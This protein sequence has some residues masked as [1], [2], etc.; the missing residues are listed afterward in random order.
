MENKRI[1]LLIL[2]IFFI[3]INSF[4]CSCVPSKLSIKQKQ[5][6]ENSECVFIG[7]VININSENNTYEIIVKESIDGNESIGEIFIGKNHK[8]CTPNITK[9][10]KWIIYGKIEGDFLVTNI[11]GISRSFENPEL[12]LYTQI[13]RLIPTMNEKEYWKNKKEKRYEKWM[14]ENKKNAQIQLKK[15]IKALRKR[16]W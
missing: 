5:E 16:E 6:I 9:K 4:A 8:Y 1:I 11:C 13:P 12:N 14:Q 2:L 15:E 10:G 7:E 3:N